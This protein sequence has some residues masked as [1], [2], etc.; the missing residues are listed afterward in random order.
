MK[1]LTEL[2]GNWND[3]KEKLECKFAMLTDDDL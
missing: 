3:I 2:N 1:Y